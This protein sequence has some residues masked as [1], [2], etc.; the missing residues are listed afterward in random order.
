[1]LGLL[2][3]IL[4]LYIRRSVPE[5][6]GWSHEHASANSV[7]GML[8]RHWKL[9]ISATLLMAFF[10]FFSH[11]TQDNYP[12]FLKVDHGFS[13][14]T[15]A[16]IQIIFNIGAI[17]G[18]LTFGSL[19]QRFGR[20]RTIITGALLSLLAMPLWAFA[21]GENW[22]L[23]ALGAFVMQ[24]LVQGC[25]GIVPAHLNEI[26]PPE[27]RATFPGLVY[28]LGN[29][30]AFFA[31]PLQTSLAPL[32]G[33][34]AIVH[35]PDYAAIVG[36]YGMALALVAVPAALGVALFTFLGH[37]AKEVDMQLAARP[38]SP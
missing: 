7:F 23:F 30:I 1:M 8:R 32:L 21:P 22:M 3:A 10:N 24:F 5:S 9:A 29:L 19:S 35:A 17:I 34:Y 18:G 37:E 27:A 6:P 4:V 31:V 11:G 33:A 26:A 38:S 25:W 28:Q 20:R 2:P 12:T 14:G 36:S 15:V 16:R 13:V